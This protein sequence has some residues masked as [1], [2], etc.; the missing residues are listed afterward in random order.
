MADTGAAGAAKKRRATKVDGGYTIT[1]NRLA[2]PKDTQVQAVE[3][4]DHV[5][6]TRT[7]QTHRL[8]DDGK[9]GEGD[10]I[11]TISVPIETFRNNTTKTKAGA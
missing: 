3:D 1:T 4:G 5:I 2:W 10:V 9:H 7:V 8:D 11:Q 6:V